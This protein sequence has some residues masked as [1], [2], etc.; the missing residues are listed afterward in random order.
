MKAS[1]LQELVMGVPVGSAYKIGKSSK[2][3]LPDSEGQ[4]SNP[5]AKSKQN[6]LNS[7][8]RRINKL[9]RKADSLAHEVREHGTYTLLKDFKLS[10]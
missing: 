2:R 9:S 8:L 4:Y 1:F 7:V 5:T 3:Y 6:R 10:V